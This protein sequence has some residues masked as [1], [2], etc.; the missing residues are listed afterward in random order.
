M[1]AVILALVGDGDD[2]GWDAHDDGGG[3]DGD[4]EVLS[5][6]WLLM[7]VESES[8][9]GGLKCSYR[10]WHP[11]LPRGDGDDDCC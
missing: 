2:A 10:L 4:D 11:R 1:A 9:S 6:S 7:V 3:D 5:R 8:L